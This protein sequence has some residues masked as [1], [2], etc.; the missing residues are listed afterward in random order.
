MAS[1][2]EQSMPK[3]CCGPTTWLYS[4]PTVLVVVRTG[5]DSTNVLPIVWVGIAS[6]NPPTIA[7]GIG[8]MHHS[9]RYI[10]EAGEVTVNVARS[11]QVAGV[12]YCGTVSGAQDPD[13][14]G[15]CGWTLVPSDRVGAPYIDECPINLKCR[16]VDRVVRATNVTYL[17]EI[18]ETHVDEEL[19]DGGRPAGAL[20]VDPLLWAPDRRYYR[21]GEVVA[22]EHEP[23]WALRGCRGVERH[24]GDD[25]YREG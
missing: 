18:L 14:V 8:K 22:L 21:L 7:L 4:M 11:N 15:T 13:K 6:G 5:P 10:D 19:L 25:A 16:V 12:D 1:Q 24:P 3:R 20:A 17:A 23:G 9:S 2:E